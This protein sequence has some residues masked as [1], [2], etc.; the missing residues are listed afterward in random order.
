MV[1]SLQFE[2]IKNIKFSAAVAFFFFF[3][4]CYKHCNEMLKICLCSAVSVKRSA[5]WD[6]ST[7]LT[8]SN[9]PMLV[10]PAC[11]MFHWLVYVCL[12]V[13]VC[14]YFVLESWLALNYWSD[15]SVALFRVVNCVL[16]PQSTYAAF[17]IF[18]KGQSEWT[19]HRL[20]DGYCL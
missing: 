18:L 17:Q 16:L 6:A 4:Q 8:G 12:C 13:W 15:V 5:S 3:K 2:F 11:W 1:D 7:C 20:E 10:E 9:C 14:V 19:F